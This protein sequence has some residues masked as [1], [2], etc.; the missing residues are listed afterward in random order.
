MLC[1]PLTTRRNHWHAQASILA[2]YAA[3][4]FHCVGEV[5]L[6]ITVNTDIGKVPVS[7]L[8]KHC[9][10]VCTAAAPPDAVILLCTNLTLH[11]QA[12][13]CEQR[14]GATVLDS[15][16]VTLWHALQLLGVDT[17]PLAQRYGRVFSLK[18]QQPRD[19]EE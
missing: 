11:G 19:G 4:G 6:R 2:N 7:A 17:Q 9:E 5:H 10:A 13:Q 18:L 15:V 14:V 3:C 8:A 1:S 12:L 16:Y